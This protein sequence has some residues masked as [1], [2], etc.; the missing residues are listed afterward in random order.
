M[1]GGPSSFAGGNYAGTP[2]DSILPVE[3]PQ[4]DKPFDS[5]AF[6]PRYTEA[7]RAAEVT[8][9]IRELLGEQLPEMV[10]TN[11]LGQAR[12]G[13][14]VLWEHP[15]LQAAG[16]NMPVL[17][18]GEAGDGRTI[19]LSVDSTHRLPSARWRRPSRGAPTVRSGTAC[20][21]G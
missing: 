8:R 3:Q 16:K 17:A 20:S 15:E 5:K 13:A 10:G 6:V 7:G 4:D 18:L 2:L 9:P 12:P 14:I 1:V 11:F 21:A 19:A